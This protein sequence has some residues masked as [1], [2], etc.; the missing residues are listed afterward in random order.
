MLNRYQTMKIG[1]ASMLFAAMGCWALADEPPAHLP[2]MYPQTGYAE[3]VN[4]QGPTVVM[5]VD[6][7]EE[8]PSRMT[9]PPGDRGA[10][11]SLDNGGDSDQESVSGEGLGENGELLPGGVGGT[12]PD[13]WSWGCCGL[14]PD[15]G[16]G[17]CD[18]PCVG[19]TWNIAVTGMVMSREDAR[20]GDIAA[21][22]AFDSLGDPLPFP[23]NIPRIF[24]Q[25][26][27]APGGRIS[28]IDR[29]P[30]C[31]GYQVQAVYE[32]IEAW[33][34]AVVFPKFSPLPDPDPLDAEVP[35]PDSSEQRRVHYRSN[36]HS[37]EVNILQC[38]NPT[39]QHYCGVRYMRFDDELRDVI[40]QEAPGPLPGPNPVV[41]TTTDRLNL[42]DMENNLMGFQ[43]GLRHDYWK[44]SS[45]WALEGFVNGGV[46]YNDIKYTNLMR[47]TTTQRY[48]DD[49]DTEVFEEQTNVATTKNMDTADL[50]EIAYSCEASL[51]AACR[52]NQC[53]VTR[54]GYQVLWI[55]GLLLADDAFLDTGVES[56]SMLFHGWHAGIECRF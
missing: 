47:V 54:A 23:L 30:S 56:R 2:T 48:A 35:S 13:D 7:P 6:A 25:F 37:G 28:I 11:Q 50:S 19:P 5:P 1:V 39:W 52:I 51:S 55:D 14:P 22:T 15:L 4:W 53:W 45:R 31:A 46:Y 29:Y 27:E 24:D 21:A 8:H 32:G 12:Y 17:P 9:M 49:T 20:L 16:L 44:V 18:P 3:L 40:D 42:F 33:E 38:Y 26:D 43:V 10:T 34:A 36:L 41:V